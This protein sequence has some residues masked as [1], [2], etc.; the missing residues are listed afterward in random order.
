MGSKNEQHMLTTIKP[1]SP[2][3]KSQ[4]WILNTRIRLTTYHAILKAY[5]NIRG[6]G[7]WIG[8]CETYTYFSLKKIRILIK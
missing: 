8:V 5:K 4:L 1:F 7:E 2:K 6:N 3:V